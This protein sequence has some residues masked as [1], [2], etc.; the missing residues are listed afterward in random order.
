MKSESYEKAK[1]MKGKRK[2]EWDRITSMNLAE[3]QR[4]TAQFDR[5]FEPKGVKPSAADKAIIKK[6]YSRVGRPRHGRAGTKVVAVSIEK[7]LLARF[8]R[9]AK[10]ARV[11][12]S[13]IVAQAFCDFIAAASVKG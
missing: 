1:M 5:E 8:D 10:K 12:R 3:L 9:V 7:S 13:E 6:F 11:K 4:E 2:A